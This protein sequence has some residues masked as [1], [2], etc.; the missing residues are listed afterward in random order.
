MS[1]N[2]KDESLQGFLYFDLVYSQRLKF[3]FHFISFQW[4]QCNKSDKFCKKINK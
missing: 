1:P 4:N 2:I 3:E